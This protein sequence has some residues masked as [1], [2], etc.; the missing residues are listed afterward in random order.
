M[1]KRKGK[2]LLASTE[3]FYLFMFNRVL[4]KDGGRIKSEK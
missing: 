4:L 1:E 3:F 2:A